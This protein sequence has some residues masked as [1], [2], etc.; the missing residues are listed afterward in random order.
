MEAGGEEVGTHDPPPLHPCHRDQ[1]TRGLGGQGAEEAWGPAR[2]LGHMLQ[3]SGGGPLPETGCF[4]GF[5][6]QTGRVLERA[7][8]LGRGVGE[9]NVE[10][11][12]W[13]PYFPYLLG[14][15]PSS[16]GGTSPRHGCWER[17]LCRPRLP[18]WHR[19]GCAAV[20][21]E[22]E[23]IKALR[24]KALRLAVPVSPCIPPPGQGHLD[25]WY[26]R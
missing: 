20:M 13:L 6:R 3:V 18:R 12:Q 17:T 15:Q 7:P 22:A 25:A 16:P 5:L 1:E 23:G 11:C 10:T 4:W 14:W 19:P 2:F 9:H 21:G 24:W 26:S 8:P